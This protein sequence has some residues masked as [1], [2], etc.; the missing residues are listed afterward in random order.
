MFGEGFPR[1]DKKML[2][3]LDKKILLGEGNKMLSGWIKN[4]C[5]GCLENKNG[6]SGWMKKMVG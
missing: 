2:L 6:F 4:G 3:G 5:S 1:F